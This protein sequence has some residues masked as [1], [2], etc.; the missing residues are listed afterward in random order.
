MFAAN[1]TDISER[2]DLDAPANQQVKKS[3]H[4]A[5]DIFP[6][7]EGEE[8]KALVADIKHRGLIH[9]IKLLGGKILDGRN[10]YRACLAAGLKPTASDYEPLPAVDPV[11]YVVSANIHRRHLTAKQKRELIAKLLK[12][13]PEKSDRQ[14]A[15]TAKASPTTVGTVR[16]EMSTVQIGQLPKRVGKDGKAR[17]QPMKKQRSPGGFIHKAKTKEAA[18]AP[19][20]PRLPSVPVPSEDDAACVAEVETIIC[21][22]L[23]KRKSGKGRNDLLSR[24]MEL[25]GKLADDVKR[26][27]EAAV[28]AERAGT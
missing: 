12:A 13:A 1:I 27:Q 25:I 22:A 7:M 5:A 26:S 18:A 20:M 21:A 10:R 3:F 11:M 9:R 15:E 4:P 16:A 2:Q 28:E 6:L 23:A 8:F 19:E 14:I 24:L 17:K